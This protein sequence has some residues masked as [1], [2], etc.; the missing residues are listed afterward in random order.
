MLKRQPA[1]CSERKTPADRRT[2][3]H[4]G[5]GHLENRHKKHETH[6]RRKTSSFAWF[7]QPDECTWCAEGDLLLCETSASSSS[8]A[9]EHQLLVIE[10]RSGT[11]RLGQHQTCLLQLFLTLKD[12]TR[13]EFIQLYSEAH[14]QMIQLWLKGVPGRAG[15]VW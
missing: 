1:R 14:T 15:C 13:A 4:H 7:S 10:V 5:Y 8:A 6:D 12:K 3:H 2:P 11:R 9:G